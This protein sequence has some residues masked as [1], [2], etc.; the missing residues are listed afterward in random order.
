MNA[1]SMPGLSPQ[2]AAQ[3]EELRRSRP[4]APRSVDS[5]IELL[6]QIDLDGWDSPCGTAL[7]GYVRETIVRPLVVTLGL[8][9]A[10][11]DEAEASAWEDVWHALTLPRLREVPAPW[12][13]LWATARRA[14]L[15]EVVCAQYPTSASRAWRLATGADGAPTEPVAQ[16]PN[17]DLGV[18]PAADPGRLIDERAALAAAVD[19]LVAVG[20]DRTTARAVVVEV[21][22]DEPDARTI[23]RARVSERSGF[24]WRSMAEQLSLPA[25]QARRLVFVLRGTAERPGLLPRLILAGGTGLPLDRDSQRALRATRDRSLASPTMPPMP[26]PAERSRR[27]G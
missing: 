22:Y 24:G 8:R 18:S 3:V 17:D 5:L 4:G 21:L 1:D 9:G 26:D 13:F 19:A 2:H 11:A 25:W 12:G 7:L 15:T 23:K 20:W 14:V 6:E 16:L 27:A 10:A